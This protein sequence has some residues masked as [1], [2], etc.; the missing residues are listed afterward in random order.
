VIT[1]FKTGNDPINRKGILDFMQDK[2]IN[3]KDIELTVDASMRRDA[4]L[5]EI[6]GDK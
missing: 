3:K 1:V 5:Q 6:L 2:W 4:K